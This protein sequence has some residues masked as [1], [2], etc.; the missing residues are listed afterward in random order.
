MFSRFRTAFGIAVL[1]A[2]LM[3][4]PALAGG[5]AVITLDELPLDVVAGESLT[6][7]FTVLQHGKTPMAGLD[8][9]V[10]IEAKTER[11]V[12]FAEEQGKPG[13]YVADIMFP[14]EGTWNWSIQAFTMDQPMPALSVAP[15]KVATAKTEPSSAS[16][17][18][19]ALSFAPALTMGIGLA[20]LA[21]AFLRKNRMAQILTAL[22]LLVGATLAFADTQ[23]SAAPGEE[24]KKTSPSDISQ[25]EYGRQLFLAKGCVTCHHNIKA[26]NSS[27]Y[28]T[29]EMGAT[30]LSN[31]SASPEALRMRLKDPS[32]VKSD[33]QMPDLELKEWEIEA[34]IAFIN[35]K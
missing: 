33:T 1:A 11:V 19:P 6:V 35:S 26:G 4:I 29:I 25:V 20:G 12:V 10:T 8:P 32:S 17:R 14:S 27:E 2:M 18:L 21:V 28:W 31:F 15:P 24:T 9:T 16:A 5:W 3:T 22:C 34:L 30:N 7:G 13:H 23:A